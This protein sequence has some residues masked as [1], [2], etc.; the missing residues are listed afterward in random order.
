M[1]MLRKVHQ[2]QLGINEYMDKPN[3][4][5]REG[6]LSDCDDVEDMLEIY[7]YAISPTLI[8]RRSWMRSGSSLNE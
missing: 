2:I 6:I 4:Q 1:R 3:D 8:W 5:L 7:Q